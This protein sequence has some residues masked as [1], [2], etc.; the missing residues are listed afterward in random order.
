MKLNKLF[1]ALS[2]GLSLAALQGA[3]WGQEGSTAA[4]AA[5]PKKPSFSVRLGTF[6]SSSGG[7][8]RIDGANGQGTVIDLKDVLNVPNNAT[9]FRARADVRVAKWFGVEGE[10]YRIARSQTAVLDREITIGDEIFA[11][12]ETV[13]SSLV[14]SYIDTALKFYLVH[15]QRLDLGLW[16][17]ATIHLIDLGVDAQP[18]GRTVEKKPWYPVPALGVC[19]NYSILPRLYLYGKAGYFYYKVDDPV[20][21]IDAVRFDITLDYYFWKALGVGVTYAYVNNTV[22]MEKSPLQ[23]MVKGTSNGIQIYATIGF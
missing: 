17:G 14:Q 11:I 5:W 16:L 18:S 4:A 13:S 23:G 15:R 9:V 3:A 20:T 10:W 8:I 21:K 7:Q 12:N 22:E 6:F 19:F 2:F 1:L